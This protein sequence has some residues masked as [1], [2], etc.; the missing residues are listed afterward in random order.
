MVQAGGQG[1]V[2]RF[3][4]MVIGDRVAVWGPHWTGLQNRGNLLSGVD[5]K[6]D[7]MGQVVFCK[8]WKWCRDFGCIYYDVPK[9][10]QSNISHSND[11][12]IVLFTS[13]VIDVECNKFTY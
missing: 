6:I 11:I 13:H 7:V 10:D 9:L 3:P 8:Q 1:I 2:P 5:L 4:Y 12:E